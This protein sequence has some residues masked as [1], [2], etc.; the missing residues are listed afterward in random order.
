MSEISVLSHE[1][2]TAAEFSQAFNRALIQ[3][4][5]YSLRPAQ[6]DSASSEGALAYRDELALALEGILQLL[7]PQDSGRSEG[8]A[9]IPGSL[10]AHLL[11]DRGDDLDRFT[12]D[13]EALVRKLRDPG[14]L[15]SSRDFELLDCIASTADE[16]TSQVFRRM[17]RK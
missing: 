6:T 5:K 15:L 2:M 14:T 7:N 3:V 9:W 12:S 13:L 4:K 17:M 1:Y 16:Q 10:I 8:I 11:K